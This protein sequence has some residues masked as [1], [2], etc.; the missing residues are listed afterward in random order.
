MKQITIGYRTEHNKGGYAAKED[1]KIKDTLTFITGFVV[2]ETEDYIMLA[3]GY[4][5]T[6]Y[7]NTHQVSKN[8]ITQGNLDITKNY[9]DDKKEDSN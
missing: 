5:A 8:Q 3:Q 4:T 6:Q 7:I 2:E 1:V 9:F